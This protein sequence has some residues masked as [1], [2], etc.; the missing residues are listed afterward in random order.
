MHHCCYQH[1]SHL[2][3]QPASRLK[4]EG[5]K[6]WKNI[7]PREEVYMQKNSRSN[8]ENCNIMLCRVHSRV[9]V[10][11]QSAGGSW[12]VH[13]MCFRCSGL[14]VNF[15]RKKRTRNKKESELRRL[16][17]RSAKDASFPGFFLL[18]Y[19]NKTPEMPGVHLE[20]NFLP[21]VGRESF[22]VK[23]K[24]TSKAAHPTIF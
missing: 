3:C 5:W 1:C 10:V 20:G 24:Q 9:I 19:S 15:L 21:H 17:R 4:T 13:T 8:F 22:L 6:S 12:H 11:S 2:Y 18:L 16:T 7:I 14:C 23:Y